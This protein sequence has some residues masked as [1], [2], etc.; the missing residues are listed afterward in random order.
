MATACRAQRPSHA[1]PD[2]DGLDSIRRMP[3]RMAAWCCSKALF[4][5][6]RRTNWR[7]ACPIALRSRQ[8]PHAV[9]DLLRQ[10]IFGLA[11][12]YRVTPND[13]EPHPRALRTQHGRW[14]KKLVTFTFT[15][16]D[17]STMRNTRH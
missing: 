4:R 16:R 2:D 12:G 17:N 1:I 10:H 15:I 13:A 9:H 7:R 6:H 3:A 11:C 5:L 14:Y 8:S